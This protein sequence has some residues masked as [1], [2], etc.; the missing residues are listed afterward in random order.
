M[1]AF[2]FEEALGSPKGAF[3]FEEAIG[4][5][6]ELGA[7][8]E[9]SALEKFA[10]SLPSWMAGEGGGV[11]GSAVGRA[12]MGA[13]DPGVAIVQ[14][15]ANLVGQGDPVNARINEVEKQYQA[16]RGA[17]GSEGFDPMRLAGNIAMTAPLGVVGGAAK[18]LPMMAAKGA[19]QG[20]IGGA[21]NPVV[22]DDPYWMQ[23]AEQI[24][25]GAGGGAIAAPIAGALARVVSPKASLNPDLKLLREEGVNPTVGQALGGAW[26]KAEEKLTS[27]PIMGDAVSGAR[28]RAVEEF[29]NAAINRATNPVGQSVS[30][31]GQGAVSKAGDV[32]SDAYESAIN[33]VKA[34]YF[35]TPEF[36]AGLGNLQQMAKSL[37]PAH[38]ARFD[39]ALNDVV[40]GRMSPTGAMLGDTFKKAESE[41]GQ[42]AAKYGKSPMAGEQELG[43]AVKELQRLMREQVARSS[44]EFAQANKAA[45]QGWANLVRVEGAAKAAVNSDGIFSPAQLNAAIKG[46]DKSVR[47]RAVARGDALMQDLGTAG[48]NVLGN[49]VPNSGTFDRAAMGVMGLG[50]GLLHPGIPAAL[51]GG[52]AAYTSPVQN[53]LV[54]LLAK[55]PDMAPMI[56][57]KMRLLSGPAAMAGGYLGSE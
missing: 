6:K 20:A 25:L 11:R 1:G 37:E 9:L 36:N 32:L 40:I 23:K 46:S 2:T 38:A 7:P 12:M 30:G 34:V 31:S 57:D 42:L 56:A 35:D 8:E 5:K 4:K 3:S 48:Q 13:A 16:A 55:R 19:A 53:F 43:D 15:V 14:G 51:I 26:N 10:S 27:L 18:T 29:N 21:L 24:A 39:R 17:E 54:R 28:R 45:N 22:G 44:P 47:G 41:L 50:T 33:K 52:A 49:K